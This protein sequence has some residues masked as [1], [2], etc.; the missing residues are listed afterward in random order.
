ML[1]ADSVLGTQ[2]FNVPASRRAVCDYSKWHLLRVDPFTRDRRYGEWIYD[3]CHGDRLVKANPTDPL[4]GSCNNDDNLFPSAKF[5]L[6]PVLPGGTVPAGMPFDAN[7]MALAEMAV[8]LHAALGHDPADP[9]NTYTVTTSLGQ[10]FA[11][12]LDDA[13]CTDVLD[14]RI[15]AWEVRWPDGHV[16]TLPGS[17]Q[18]GITDTR[19]LPPGRSPDPQTTQVV[20][21]AHLHITAQAVDFDA[22]ATP[23]VRTV[24]AD[25]VIS[26]DPAAAGGGGGAPVYTPPQ[27]TAPAIC[28]GQAGDGTIPVYDPL[29]PRRTACDTLRGRLLEVFPQVEVVQPGQEVVGGVGVGQA[30]SVVEGWTYLGETTD[31]PAREATAPGAGGDAG[32]PI[33]VQY[34]HVARIDPGS[35]RPVPEQVPYRV[36]VRTTYPD[37][38]QEIEQVTGSV[39]VTI[40]YVGLNFEP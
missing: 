19:T 5:S 7:C 11:S 33:D 6:C 23:Y 17:G 36:T 40:Y 13:T 38:H 2:D 10:D 3:S 15:T 35:G 1:H 18:Q 28:Q 26:N 39:A 27:L 9:A 4:S 20:V 32:T 34:N 30:R 16:D 31:A 25:V 14:W 37:G 22:G 21:R 8:S 29:L 12:R 24:S